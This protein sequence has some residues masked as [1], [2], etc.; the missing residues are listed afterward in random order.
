MSDSGFLK[1]PFTLDFIWITGLLC[2]SYVTLGTPF[3]WGRTTVTNLW[4]RKK[5][6]PS[7]MWKQG[8]AALD[9]ISTKA[10]VLCRP[11]L[12]P[13]TSFV[14]HFT[15]KMKNF[16]SLFFFFQKLP[17]FIMGLNTMGTRV[18]VSDIQESFHFVKFKARENHL[19]IFADDV[20]PRY[21]IFC[22]TRF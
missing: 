13:L 17:N 3:S 9:V 21:V 7:Q 4:S 15:Y 8:M 6:A 18:V 1:L 19:V 14:C 2:L 22:F 20:N 16:L 12:L 11:I 5:E 10:T